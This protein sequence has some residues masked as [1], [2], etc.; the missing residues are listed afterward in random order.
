MQ[1]TYPGWLI[2]F[3]T[4]S[5]SN[6]FFSNLIVAVITLMMGFIIGRICGRLVKKV[7][8]ELELDNLLKEAVKKQLNVESCIGSSVSGVIY[9]GTIIVV[10]NQIGLLVI[11]AYGVI[12][13]IG[14]IVILSLM[15]WLKDLVPNVQ[16]G[17]SLHRQKIFSMG[18]KIK[19]RTMVGEVTSFSLV[20]TRIRTP[21]HDLLLIPNSLLV[22]EKISKFAENDSQ[23]TIGQFNST[24]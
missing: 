21:D 18:D 17:I 22:H 7:L 11:A 10:L 2:K 15:L 6:S 24:Q 8:E 16:A 1:V 4:A 9:L 23:K 5:L 14:M 3:A 19:V 13:A 20:E 12:I